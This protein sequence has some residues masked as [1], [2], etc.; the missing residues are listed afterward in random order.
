MKDQQRDYKRDN[1]TAKE[2]IQKENEF[3]KNDVIGQGV[4]SDDEAER[5]QNDQSNIERAQEK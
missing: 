4:E 3:L 1:Q 5:E 2:A